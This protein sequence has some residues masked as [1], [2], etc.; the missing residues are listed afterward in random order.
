MNP[1]AMEVVCVDDGS[2]DG[3]RE[4]L[5]LLQRGGSVDVAITH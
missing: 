2:S 1:T 3:S 4:V 5:S